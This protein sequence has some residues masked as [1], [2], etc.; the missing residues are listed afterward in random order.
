MPV[1]TVSSSSK[2]CCRPSLMVA[3]VGHGQAR[4]FPVSPWVPAL[5][6]ALVGLGS[7]LLAPPNPAEP[8]PGG[9]SWWIPPLMWGLKPVES[10]LPKPSRLATAS[11]PGTKQP[12]GHQ[13][14]H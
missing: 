10:G 3:M 8:Q 5:G 9:S 7:G 1:L 2:H 11:A 14:P 4:P 12:L 13:H 6:D